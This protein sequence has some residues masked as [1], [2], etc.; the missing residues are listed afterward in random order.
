[1]AMRSVMGVWAVNALFRSRGVRRWLYGVGS[2]GCAHLHFVCGAF[3]DVGRVVGF[4][5]HAQLW[6][7]G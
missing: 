5:G 4:M 2:G 1:M 3:R 7:C 6:V